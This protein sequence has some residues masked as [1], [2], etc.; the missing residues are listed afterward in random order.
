VTSYF[1]IGGTQMK[2][3]GKLK[4]WIDTVKDFID[5]DCKKKRKQADAVLKIL[6]KLKKEKESLEKDL[7][8]EK[9]K[10]KIKNIKNKLEIISI[11]SKKAN[12]LFEKCEERH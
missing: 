2:L 3:S 7:K 4:K 8:N 5:A 9:D 12:K 6:T 1:I 11:Q 10:N